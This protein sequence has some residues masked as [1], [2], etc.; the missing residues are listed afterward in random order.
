MITRLG[1][2]RGRSPTKE[3]LAWSIGSTL[4]TPSTLKLPAKLA[5]MDA[6]RHHKRP[7]PP[8]T[9][10]AKLHLRATLLDL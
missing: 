4:R 3:G 1:A 10:P 7:G 5:A 8:N 9:G 2:W 6:P